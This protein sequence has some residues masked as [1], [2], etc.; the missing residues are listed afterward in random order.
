[1]SKLRQLLLSFGKFSLRALRIIFPPGT[2]IGIAF[3]IALFIL[4]LLGNSGMSVMGVKS[5]VIEQAIWRDFLNHIIWVQVKLLLGYIAVGW[6]VG[7]GSRLWWELLFKSFKLRKTGWRMILLTVFTVPMVHFMFL[8]ASIIRYPQLYADVMYDSGGF[9]RNLQLFLTDNIPLGLFTALALIVAVL[10]LLMLM[11]VGWDQNLARKALTLSHTLWKG[12]RKALIGVTV[13]MVVPI[14]FLLMPRPT[15]SKGPNVLIIGVDSLRPDHLGVNGYK[16]TNISPHI[17]K[18]ARAG[19]NFYNFFISLPRTFPSWI[20]LLTGQYAH[21]HGVRH[22]FPTIEDRAKKFNTLPRLLKQKGYQSAV[23]ADYAGDIFSR[24]DLG[25]DKVESPFFSFAILVDIRSFEI[26][27][28]LLPY[29]TTS[30][31]RRIYPNL[32]EM[33]QNSDARDLADRVIAQLKSYSRTEKFFLATFFSTVHF[34]YAAP[35][36]YYKSYTRPDYRGRFKYHKFN[37]ITQQQVLN[38]KEISHINDLYD[39]TIKAMDD[40]IGR[41]MAALKRLKLNEKTIVIIYSDHG[42]HLYERM[43][44]GMGHGDHFRGDEATRATLIITD[45]RMKPG[46]KPIKALV[47]D[48]DVFPTLLERLGVPCPKKKR[49]GTS[50]TP[51]MDGRQSDLNLAAF[52]ETGIWFNNQGDEFFH[53]QRIYY[54]NIAGL[55][56]IDYKHRFEIVLKDSFKNLITLSKHRMIRTKDYKLIYIPTRQGV[57]YELYDL[58]K[59]PDQV[60]DLAGEQPK[61]IAALKKRLFKWMLGDKGTTLKGD[62]I[63]PPLRPAPTIKKNKPG[64]PKVIARKG[65]GHAS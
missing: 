9:L 37:V 19:H 24:V 43:D 31:G 58:K 22:M 36:P 55:G 16:R 20:T 62:F 52:G 30:L 33:V 44:R 34:P 13:V 45:P 4:A 1:M 27:K 32:R 21:H 63:L 60:K 8:C 14:A 41:I 50:L 2:P 56:R 54:P 29:I 40:Q 23:L 61:I 18:I 17:D 6:L 7:A 12:H 48:V 25:F 5:Q 47:R 38:K 46:D 39:G 51:L 57:K 28:H 35:Y 64:K 11:K 26:H 15:T 59:D 3:Y 53:K 49:D 65:L 42:E 10:A